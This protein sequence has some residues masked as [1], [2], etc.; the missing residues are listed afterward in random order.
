LRPAEPAARAEGG[1]RRFL[2]R[3]DEP[4]ARQQESA[5]E[6]PMLARLR[7]AISSARE[8]EALV[9]ELPVLAQPRAMA[10]AFLG[11]VVEMFSPQVAAVFAPSFDGSFGV[12]AGHGLSAVEAGMKVPP[13]QPLF[14]EITQ[15]LEAVLVAPV[16]LAQGLVAGIGGARTEALIAAPLAVGGVCHA[17]VVVG[18]QDFS[19]FELELLAEQAEEAAPG[20]AV[21]QMIDRLRGL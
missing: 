13:E 7:H 16:D 5:P 3:K 4:S 12:I 18:R 1:L 10:H 6:D 2:R 15:T 20:L 19:E 9:H 17:I 11:E 8:L 14:L 21:A